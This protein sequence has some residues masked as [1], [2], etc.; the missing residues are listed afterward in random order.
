MLKGQLVNE[1]FNGDFIVA[2]GVYRP[3][4][5]EK[6]SYFGK[7]RIQGGLYNTFLDVNSLV[8]LNKSL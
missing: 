2:S 7:Q 1:V 3:I 5:I 8:V 6:E 4:V